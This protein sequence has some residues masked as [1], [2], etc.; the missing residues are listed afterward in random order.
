MTSGYNLIKQ[1]N[2]N[3]SLKATCEDFIWTVSTFSSLFGSFAGYNMLVALCTTSLTIEVGIAVG[4]L[5]SLFT[6]KKTLK[7]KTKHKENI[8]VKCA[9]KKSPVT[10]I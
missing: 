5:F 10:E 1:L 6:R 4:V 2:T 9:G 8:C 3:A 7:H